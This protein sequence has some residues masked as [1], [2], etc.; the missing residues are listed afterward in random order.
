MSNKMAH[1]ILCFKRANGS[2][3]RTKE[4]LDW[5]KGRN[6]SRGLNQYRRDMKC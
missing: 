1:I 4:V 5:S 2:R 3:D 6:V